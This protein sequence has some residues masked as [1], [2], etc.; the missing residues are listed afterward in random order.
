[1]SLPEASREARAASVVATPG[2]EPVLATSRDLHKLVT[3]LFGAKGN[4]EHHPWICPTPP[5]S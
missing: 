2:G 1:M 4:S 3:S 5:S